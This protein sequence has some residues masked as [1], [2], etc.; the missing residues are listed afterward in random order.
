M[1]GAAISVDDKFSACDNLFK[2]C[3]IPSAE[4]SEFSVL[5][6]DNYIHHN[7]HSTQNHGAA[8]YGMIMHS[9]GFA[10]IYQNVFDFNRHAITAGGNA[11]GYHAL[12][13]SM[14]ASL[15]FAT[16]IARPAMLG[17]IGKTSPGLKRTDSLF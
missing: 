1:G 3:S 5:I 7:Q 8:G 10:A 12:T 15:F 9:G 14:A 17:S 13:S 2:N 4:P 6:H 11:G 16:S